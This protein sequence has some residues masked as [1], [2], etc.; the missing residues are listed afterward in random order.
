MLKKEKLIVIEELQQINEEMRKIAGCGVLV[1][2]PNTNSG[3]EAGGMRVKGPAWSTQWNLIQQEKKKVRIM[4]YMQDLEMADQTTWW[5][6]DEKQ[7]I[8]IISVSFFT[9]AEPQ[10]E[11]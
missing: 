3:V 6:C 8:F 11:K 1:H 9:C 2:N 10:G 4:C 5:N 7:Y